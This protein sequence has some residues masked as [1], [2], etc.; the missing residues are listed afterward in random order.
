MIKASTEDGEPI[1]PI[2][3]AK[4]MTSE[5]ARDWEPRVTDFGKP[6]IRRSGWEITEI[7]SGF[8][9]AIALSSRYRFEGIG[10]QPSTALE[11]AYG[12]ILA[13]TKS[14]AEHY[15][16]MKEFANELKWGEVET[17]TMRALRK[18]LA[19]PS[20]YVQR[21]EKMYKGEE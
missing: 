7:S 9:K 17:D 20:G 19:S 13:S 6:Q 1:S 2:D 8:F 4:E 16:L 5:L 14:A 21:F 18:H 11:S 3:R 10:H 12:Q 15:H